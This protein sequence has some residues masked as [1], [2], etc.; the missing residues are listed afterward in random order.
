[1]KT[2]M[3]TQN[4][5]EPM[6]LAPVADD[7]PSGLD[8]IRQEAYDWIVR[9][10]TGQM[11]PADVEVMKTWYRQSP[12]HKLAYAEARRVWK[13]LGPIASESHR[14]VGEGE[15]VPIT[16]TPRRASPSM[17][18]RRLFLGGAVAATAASVAYVAVRPPLDLWP[19]YTELMADFRTGAGERRQVLLSDNVSLDLN[20]RTSIAVRSQSPVVTQIELLSGEAA[21]ST[22]ASAPP[23][24]V[25]A[26]EGR[27]IATD[28]EFN[29]RCEDAQV[30]ISCL[31]GR[32]E[33]E[34]R[35]QT[36]SIA[37]RQQVK[38]GA[39]GMGAIAAFDPDSITAWQQGVLTFDGTPVDQVISEINR[40]RP[41]RIIL[42]NGS[43]G[44][45]LLNARIKVAETDKIIV[46][47]VHIFGAKAR[48]L[49]GGVVI[50]S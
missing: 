29:L 16:H 33:V 50:L 14:R 42:M 37:C 22:G 25:I 36:M 10:T 43:I 20:T 1:M 38:Y 45:R 6:S 32:L 19:S 4:E 27:L 9:F 24:T 17:P 30:S 48:E 18:G 28:A 31:K 21:I 39:Q 26:A 15:I 2:A 41:G 7:I 35:G 8:P 44:R 23:L 5:P 12:A 34:H 13:S 11:T 3:T 46:Q 49:P 40:Y 47:I